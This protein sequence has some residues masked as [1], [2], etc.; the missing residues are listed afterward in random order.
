MGTEGPGLG[1]RQG[2]ERACLPPPPEHLRSLLLLPCAPA[3]CSAL[4]QARPFFLPPSSSSHL[5]AVLLLE[6][7]PPGA[8]HLSSGRCLTSSPPILPPPVPLTPGCVLPTRICPLAPCSISGVSMPW[9]PILVPL[10]PRSRG[11]QILTTSLWGPDPSAH[12]FTHSL[13]QDL[14]PAK[15]CPI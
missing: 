14:G 11:A 8:Q 2:W 7:C 12:S 5:L 6:W 15:S 1:W 9:A 10:I 13:T 4:R 3:R